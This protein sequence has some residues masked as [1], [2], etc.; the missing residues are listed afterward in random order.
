MMAKIEWANVRNP[1]HRLGE[2]VGKVSV[3][4]R[5]WGYAR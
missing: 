2:V 4:A 3:K 5:R 1:T